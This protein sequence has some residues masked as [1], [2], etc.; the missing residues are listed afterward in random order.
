MAPTTQQ[1]WIVKKQGVPK[2]AVVFETQHPVKKPG[3]GEVIVKVQAAALN[4]VC[5]VLLFVIPVFLYRVQWI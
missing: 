1:A 2:D 5:V 4:P 3:K